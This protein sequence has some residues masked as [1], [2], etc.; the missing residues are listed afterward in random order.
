MILM[1]FRKVAVQA[2]REAGKVIR[3]NFGRVQ[4]VS[5]K[6]G[7]W[8]DLVT[9]VDLEAN[10][11]ILDILESEFPGHGIISEESRPVAGKDY[12][13]YVDP[14]DGTTN[15]TLAFP[16]V[17]T[18]MGLVFRGRPVLGVVYNPM[19]DEMFMGEDGKGATL[20]GRRIRVSGNGDLRKTIVSF[21]HNNTP[22]S[23]ETVGR[24]FSYFKT[25]ARDYRKLGSGNLEICYVAC[26]RNDVYFRPDLISYDVVAGYVVAKEAGARITDWSG[27]ELTM[28][29]GD[30]L[31]T[32]G[33][34][35][36]GK[37][38]DI[39]RRRGAEQ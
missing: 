9:G 18:C 32:N 23:I 17:G 35:I 3:E 25:N 20:N 10:K 27:T 39:L 14:L 2:V 12:T 13:W 21:C 5:I 22:G 8:R 30:I 11:I 24:V 16:F 15:Y 7:D 33:T 6:H 29:S 34:A 28:E 31:V 1:D 4:E 19:A 36:H 37:V 26:G 38:L